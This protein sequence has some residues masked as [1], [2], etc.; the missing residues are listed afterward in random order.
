M[1]YNEY[2]SLVDLY[3]KL[4]Q[5]FPE[6]VKVFKKEL[7]NIGALDLS[8]EE[9]RKKF[10]D[11]LWENA[12][13]FN[14]HLFPKDLEYI[15]DVIKRDKI[16][17]LINFNHV[18]GLDKNQFNNSLIRRLLCYEHFYNDEECPKQLKKVLYV[19]IG[20]TKERISK[21]VQKQQRNALMELWF[22][23]VR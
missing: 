22:D 3:K 20:T 2:F 6:D 16:F 18:T 5:P 17:N 4:G 13:L 23:R 8:N 14:I 10:P 9:I 1:I 11:Q 15:N 19:L 21:D 7:V 12:V